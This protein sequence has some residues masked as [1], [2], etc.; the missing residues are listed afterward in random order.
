MGLLNIFKKNS[1]DGD[2][3][4]N[5]INERADMLNFSDE[6]RAIVNVETAKA[7]GEFV[8]NTLDENTERSKARRSIALL[9]VGNTIVIFWTVVAIYN[10]NVE[11][12]LFIKD[13]ATS[14]GFSTGFLMVL[15]FFFGSYLLK[16]TPFKK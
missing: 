1:V 3:L 7:W 4:I 14:I 2:N 12:A 10:Y 6:E 8:T 16:G 15:G 11:L 13:F 9:L 5:K